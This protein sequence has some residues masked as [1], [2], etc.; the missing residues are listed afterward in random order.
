[1]SQ[2]LPTGEFEKL[3]FDDNYNL[4]EIIEDLLQIP[5]D[6]ESRFFHRNVI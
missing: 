3:T 2:P 4:N 6:N 1:M 5:D